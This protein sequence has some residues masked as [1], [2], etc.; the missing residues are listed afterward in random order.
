MIGPVKT[1]GVYVEDQQKALEFY[2]SKLGFEVH[3]TLPMGSDAQWIEV[4]P[5]GAQTCLVLYPKSLMANWSELKPS[6]VF[7]CRDV[8][9]TCLR[10]AS[11]GVE[12]TMNPTP[13]AW[14]TFAKFRDPDGNEFG[15]TSQPLA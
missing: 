3:R 5:A 15:L 7:H 4:G 11:N 1:V 8:E 2:T 13:M 12:V 9:A 6:I 10:L 14:G